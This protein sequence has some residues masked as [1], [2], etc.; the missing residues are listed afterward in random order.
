[1]KP[2]LDERSKEG[3]EVRL[4]GGGE[5]SHRG[6][7]GERIGSRREV[8]EEGRERKGEERLRGREGGR[9]N[10]KATCN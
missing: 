6:A 8:Q 3:V 2:G 5:N 10:S 4:A 9:L 7:A 1:M